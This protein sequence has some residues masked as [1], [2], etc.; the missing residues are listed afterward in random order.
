MNSSKTLF[1]FLNLGLAF[2]QDQLS[3]NLDDLVFMVQD[4][5]ILEETDIDLKFKTLF[6]SRDDLGYISMR[7]GVSVYQSDGELKENNYIESEFGHW[8]QLGWNFHRSVKHGEFVESEVAIRSPTCTQ[9]KRFADHGFFD[10]SLAPC[11]Y[12]CH[13]FRI[14]MNEAGCVNGVYGMKFTSEVGWGSMRQDKPTEY[15]QE[16]VGYIYERNRCSDIKSPGPI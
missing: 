12:D 15:T 4:D 5:V 13:D 3:P 14:R 2:I 7:L 8:N 11:G 10:L 16:K 9:W 1:S 6:E